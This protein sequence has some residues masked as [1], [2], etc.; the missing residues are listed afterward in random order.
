MK[1]VHDAP[2][3]FSKPSSATQLLKLVSN[4]NCCCTI[5]TYAYNLSQ[6]KR[7]LNVS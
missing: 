5:A 7:D 1:V 6:V 2:K 3:L 4:L